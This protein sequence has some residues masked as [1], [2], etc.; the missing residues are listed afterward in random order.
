VL[1]AFDANRNRRETMIMVRTGLSRIKEF[2]KIEE[3]VEK[4]DAGQFTTRPERVN[5]PKGWDAKQL[6]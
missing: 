5:H 1:A 4:V 3:V 2:H 6:A